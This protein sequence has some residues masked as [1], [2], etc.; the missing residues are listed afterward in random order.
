MIRPAVQM[1]HTFA[2]LHIAAGESITWVSKMLR[3]SDVE[4]T[5]KRYNR[6]IPNLMRED[7]SAFEKVF[8][9]SEIGNDLVSQPS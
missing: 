8:N 1:R 3:H 6:F 5:L 9:K 4:T 2:T 7:G